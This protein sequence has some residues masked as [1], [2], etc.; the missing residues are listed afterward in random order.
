MNDITNKNLRVNGVNAENYT[1]QDAVLVNL[2]DFVNGTETAILQLEGG[3]IITG[4]E[5][6]VAEATNAAASTTMVFNVNYDGSTVAGTAFATVTLGSSATI[7]KT[8]VAS[9]SA[10]DTGCNVAGH[11]PVVTVTTNTASLTGQ[12][13]VIVRSIPLKRF[14]ENG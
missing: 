13:F 11:V 4:V 14:L 3:S 10:K 2:A 8:S 12:V 9:V 7:G 1:K 5:A 6:I